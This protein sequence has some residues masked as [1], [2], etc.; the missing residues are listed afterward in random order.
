MAKVIFD[1]ETK[2]WFAQHPSAEITVWKCSKCGL[3]F[4][5]TLG[6]KCKGEKDG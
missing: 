3:W 4:K 5:P 6:H 2:K 1:K